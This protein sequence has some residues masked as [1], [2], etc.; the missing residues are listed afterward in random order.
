MDDELFGPTGPLG[1][2]NKKQGKG[3]IDVWWLYD[4]GGTT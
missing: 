1:V 2:F 4:D 3:M